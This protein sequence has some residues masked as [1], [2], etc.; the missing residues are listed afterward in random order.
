MVLSN[1]PDVSSIVKLA[2]MTFMQNQQTVGM[3]I[4]VIKDGKAY[5]FNFGWTDLSTKQPPTDRT[6]YAIGSIS[7]TFTG[8]L[9]AQADL[10]KKASLEDDVRKY[11][12]E[13]Y[14]NLEFQGEPIRLW[15]L[16]NHTSGLPGNLPESTT[17]LFGP[18]FDFAR[19][20]M[21]EQKSFDAYTTQAFLRDLH[22]VKLTRMPG[23]QFSY[24]NAAAQLLGIIL[25]KIYGKPYDELVQAKIAGPLKMTATKAK[26]TKKEEARM[27]RAYSHDKPFLPALPTQLP[28]AGSIKSTCA[29]MLKYLAWQLKETDPAVLF[30]HRKTGNTVWDPNGNFYVGLNWQILKSATQRNIFQD[31]NV[32]GF[33]CMIS[34]CPE[35]KI[36]V[37]VLTN[38]RVQERPAQLSPLVNQILKGLDPEVLLAP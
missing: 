2:G 10:E 5:S 8:L 18:N 20:S 16:V 4:G 29:D 13:D 31:G 12:A 22:L 25:E 6:R 24:S 37:V 23:P 17:A 34:F 36:G 3:S 19:A 32:P 33:H 15:Q 35:R 21:Q 38:E 7:K 11:L 1:T 27:P 26:L 30:S 9:L 14:P 28:A